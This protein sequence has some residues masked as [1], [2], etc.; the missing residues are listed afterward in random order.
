VDCS[1]RGLFRFEQDSQGTPL[2]AGRAIGS[3]SPSFFWWTVARKITVRVLGWDIFAR[4]FDSFLSGF[5]GF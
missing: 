5:D 1:I 3:G 2:L 4:L